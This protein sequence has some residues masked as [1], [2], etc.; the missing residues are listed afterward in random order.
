M[1]S[2]SSEIWFFHMYGFVQVNNNYIQ[3][4]V[5][6]ATTATKQQQQQKE[7]EK[8][9]K[10]GFKEICSFCFYS[11]QQKREWKRSA[12]TTVFVVQIAGK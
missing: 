3:Q 8:T 6:M 10:K 9:I 1:A 5:Y 4:L 2:Q 11:Q 12:N 7:K